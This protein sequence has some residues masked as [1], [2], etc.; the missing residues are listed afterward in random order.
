MNNNLQPLANYSELQTRFIKYDYSITY[1]LNQAVKSSTYYHSQLLNNISNVFCVN[2]YADI[3]TYLSASSN[4]DYC[5]GKFFV[6]SDARD[7]NSYWFTLHYTQN[8]AQQTVVSCTYINANNI[9]THTQDDSS[10]NNYQ[11]F[12]SS[13]N[14]F[15]NPIL[16]V[17][18]TT[19]GTLILTANIKYTI[20]A[21][22]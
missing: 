10:Y 15:N 16:S 17:Y 22:A 14:I 13:I 18:C 9:Y 12:N 8:V 21:F 20:L 6:S 5:R 4:R 7:N 1:T 2:V 3:S 11:W 19:S